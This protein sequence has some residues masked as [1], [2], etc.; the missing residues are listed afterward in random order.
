MPTIR[1]IL[2]AEINKYQGLKYKS[3]SSRAAGT[4]SPTTTVGA[5]TGLRTDGQGPTVVPGW[6]GWL[7]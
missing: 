7:R 5:D 6:A 2:T 3:K 1:V 4:L